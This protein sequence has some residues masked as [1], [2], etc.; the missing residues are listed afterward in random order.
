MS[1]Y[2]KYAQ[3]PTWGDEII[4]F[5]I[6]R[7]NSF[8][9][10]VYECR[11]VFVLCWFFEFLSKSNVVKRLAVSSSKKKKNSKIFFMFVCSQNIFTFFFLLSCCLVCISV[12]HSL[13]VSPS[14]D[15]KKTWAQRFIEQPIELLLTQIRSYSNLCEI[16]VVGNHL[17]SSSKQKK[18]YLAGVDHFRNSL[19]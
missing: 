19:S 15:Y 12:R 3:F 9:I 10:Q 4:S 13:H 2:A 6:W 11:T 14:D 17:L 18:V 7:T 5:V 1:K 16:F 8:S